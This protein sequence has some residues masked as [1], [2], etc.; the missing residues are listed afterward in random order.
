[1]TFNLP[2][3]PGLYGRLWPFL[4]NDAYHTSFLINLEKEVARSG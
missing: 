2:A 1:M 4:S 3:A